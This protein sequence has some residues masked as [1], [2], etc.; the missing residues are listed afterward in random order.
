MV[1]YLSRTVLSSRGGEEDALLPAAL[2]GPAAPHESARGRVL[3][4]P[5]VEHALPASAL[6]VQLGEMLSA[7]SGPGLPGL[8]V[9]LGEMVPAPDGGGGSPGGAD[10][11]HALAPTGGRVLPDSALPVQT[12]AAPLTGSDLPP[13]RE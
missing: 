3:P 10:G 7:G 9:P 5:A 2:L 11:G 4:Q 6:P 12:G 8:M 1:I 13:V